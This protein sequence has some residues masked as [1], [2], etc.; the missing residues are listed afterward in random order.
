MKRFN[1]RLDALK[2]LAIADESLQQIELAKREHA[3][4]EAIGRVSD[5]EATANAS[6]ARLQRLV[7]A[8]RA[9]PRDVSIA[10]R[11]MDDAARLTACARA[12]AL[13]RRKDADEAR[14]RLEEHVMRRRMLER[15]EVR[16]RAAHTVEAVRD[17]QKEMDELATRSGEGERA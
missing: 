9:L 5:G 10:I 8:E 6:R 4:S 14:A 11:E 17:E 15:L 2:R 3:L 1:F 13:A 12:E 16:A 7:D